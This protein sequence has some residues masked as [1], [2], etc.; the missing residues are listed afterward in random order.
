MSEPA[1]DDLRL[2]LHGLQRLLSSRRVFS[3]LAGAAGV[4]LSQQSAEVLS[5]LADGGS[6]PVAEVARRA[7][8]DVAAVSRQLRTLEER[9]LARRRPSPDHRSVVMVEATARGRRVADQIDVVRRRHLED[10]LTSWSTEERAQFGALLLR[11]V[12]GLQQTPFHAPSALLVSR[13]RRSFR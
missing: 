12:E 2:G 8:M 13:R 7:R 5:A 4:D 11:F 9:Q 3:N 6:R 10:A 1:V